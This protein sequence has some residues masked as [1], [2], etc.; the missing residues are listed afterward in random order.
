MFEV[1]FIERIN[2]LSVLSILADILARPHRMSARWR[3]G[4]GFLEEI[5]ALRI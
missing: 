1:A 3:Y 2:I 4:G 5:N